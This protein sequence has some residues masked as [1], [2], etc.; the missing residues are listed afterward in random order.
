MS[1][2]LTNPTRYGQFAHGHPSLNTPQRSVNA[3]PMG[4]FIIPACL[5]GIAVLPKSFFDEAVAKGYKDCRIRVAN[6][7]PNSQRNTWLATVPTLKFSKS[8]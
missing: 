4:D 2:W 3:R 8:D 7:L 5:S 6:A 1:R